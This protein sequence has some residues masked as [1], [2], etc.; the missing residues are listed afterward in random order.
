MIKA[1]TKQF[2]K[3]IFLRDRIHRLTF[4]DAGFFFVLKKQMKSPLEMKVKPSLKHVAEQHDV[5]KL[6][7]SVRLA[8]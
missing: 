5:K 8:T 7:Y 2:L 4:V 6:L 3:T 1:K